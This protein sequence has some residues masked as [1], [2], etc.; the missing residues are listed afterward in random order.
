MGVVDL[1]ADR[2]AWTNHKLQ[3]AYHDPSSTQRSR[4]DWS[5]GTLW[6]CGSDRGSENAWCQHLAIL[7]VHPIEIVWYRDPTKNGIV[8]EP[9]TINWKCMA[10]QLA[11]AN[12]IS[13]TNG[14]VD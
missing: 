11:L 4:V 1:Q 13:H 14:M 2:C 8:L 7:I 10:V 5:T 3:T 6:H 12:W 9:I